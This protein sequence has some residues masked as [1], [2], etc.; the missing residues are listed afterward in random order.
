M[1]RF[2]LRV[3]VLSLLA[4]VTIVAA[5]SD[6]TTEPDPSPLAGL[7]ARASAD[8]AGNAAPPPPTGAPT[9]G[10]FRGTVLGPSEPGAGNDS[11]A[12]APRVSGAVVTAFPILSGSGAT[13][14]LGDA[15]AT[16]T[17]DANGRFTLPTLA[18]GEYVVTIN[19]PAA[20][21]YG[22]VWVTATAHSGSDEHPWWIVLWKK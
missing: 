9:D 15:A 8:S 14:Q 20:S 10:H 21:I 7:L 18:G 16:T 5:C 22:G 17:T 2:P 1:N 11:L 12:T 3:R 19:P 13:A 6:S 4:A